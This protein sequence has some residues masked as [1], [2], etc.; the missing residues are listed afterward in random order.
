MSYIYI[1]FNFLVYIYLFINLYI[2]ISFILYLNKKND[3][4]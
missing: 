4:I 3:N 2:Y 1:I